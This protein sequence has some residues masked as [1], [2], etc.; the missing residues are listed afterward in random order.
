MTTNL[1][2]NDYKLTDGAAWF[3]VKDFAIRIHSTDEGVVVDVFDAALLKADIFC[4]PVA[5][6]YA[7]DSDLGSEQ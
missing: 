2:D 3:D 5:S 7:F 6:T 4:G 1:V